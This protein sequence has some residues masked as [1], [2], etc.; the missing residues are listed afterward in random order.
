MRRAIDEFRPDIVH[1][2][3]AYH[4]LS[5]S[6]FP[7]ISKCGIPI[8]MTVHDYIAVS[9]DKDRY[10]DE[11]GTSF[12]KFLSVRK[13]SFPKR[14]LLVLRAY[15]DAR[16]GY[17]S[18]YVDMFI[19]P[20][21]Y[22]KETLIRAG[23]PEAKIR[24]IP[25][26]VSDAEVHT[27]IS[28]SVAPYALSAGSVSEDK[29]IGSLVALFISIGY[30]LILAGRKTMEISEDDRIRFVGEKA[31]EELETLYSGASFVVSASRLP[32]TFGLV[33]LEA[34]A[35]GRP[36]IGFD[37][38]ALSEIVEEGKTGTLVETDA[39]LESAL[40][41]FIAHPD[42]YDSAETIRRKT[43]DRFGKQKYLDSF[44]SLVH[45]LLSRPK[46]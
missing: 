31:K 32:E 37:T 15:W 2:H 24:V 35:A 1:I 39:E 26:F 23:I 9:P 22:V 41:S 28:K 16:M 27:S 33:A 4:Q 44:F 30:P 46:G 14:F 18:R 5:L 3:N 29:N 34:G 45:E 11:I 10:D 12:W 21:Q 25:H 6:F 8:I 13:Y 17:Y 36:Y 7:I 40:R 42:T 20:S 38:G 19:A 43:I